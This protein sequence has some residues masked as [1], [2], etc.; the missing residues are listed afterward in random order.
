MIPQKK[1][2]TISFLVV[3]LTFISCSPIVRLLY[4][5]K[6]PKVENEESLKKYLEKVNISDKDVYTLDFEGYQKALE[7]INKKIPEVLIFDKNGNYIPYGNEWAC[8]ASAFDFIENLNDT[9]KYVNSDKTNII[10]LPFSLYSLEG[11]SLG[12]PTL[13]A[14]FH[15][16]IFWA[17]FAGKLNKDH[18]KIWEKQA[19]N[20][21]NANIKVYKI[22]MDFQEHWGED[23][24]SQLKSK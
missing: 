19:I 23:V 6:K 21:S 22:N 8:N 3:I 10:S 4:G 17:K 14:S 5:I 9:T 1:L 15:I 18:V 13:N 12:I 24:T 11:D 2:F 7:L 16:F 20:N